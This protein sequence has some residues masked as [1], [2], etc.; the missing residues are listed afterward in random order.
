M[1][2]AHAP[3]KVYEKVWQDKRGTSSDRTGSRQPASVQNGS[4]SPGVSTTIP[5]SQTGHAAKMKAAPL[6]VWVN[7]IVKAEI[8]RMAEINGV[9]ASAQGAALLEEILRQTLHIQ[10]AATLET[11]LEKIIAKAHRSL[12]TRMAWLLVR[13]AFDTGISRVLTTNM[14][15][16]QNGM[17][18]KEFNDILA[19]ADKRTKANLMRKTPQLTELVEAVEQWLLA[20]EE[21]G[22]TN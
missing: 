4:R 18:E 2:T 16:R 3:Q 6:Q 11:V 9:S 17:T 21:E 1:K 12:A 10:Q 5:R 15:G 7:P 14:L 19:T 22:K 13:I 8:K 20:G